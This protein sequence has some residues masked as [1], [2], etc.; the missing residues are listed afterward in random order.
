MVNA[1]DLAFQERPNAFDA[2]RM[3]EAAKA[4]IFAFGVIDG[5]VVI[6]AVEADERTVFIRQDCRAFG[7]IAA[8]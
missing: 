4:D 6:V 7:D 8:D 2:V 5:Q 1:D 3:D